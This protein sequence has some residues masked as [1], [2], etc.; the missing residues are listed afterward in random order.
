MSPP[1][2][3]HT[4]GS[5]TLIDAP[6]LARG[7]VEVE[8]TY[9][10]HTHANV[11]AVGIA[12]AVDAPWHSANAVGVPKIGFPVETMARV[13]ADN[14]VAQVR[15]EQPSREESFAGIPAVCI[16]DAGNNGVTILADHMLPRASTACA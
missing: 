6:L 5:Q 4:Q 11:Y 9:R 13:A 2:S 10:T 3:A 7:F 14:I 16:T 15:G 1:Y 8:H 12:T